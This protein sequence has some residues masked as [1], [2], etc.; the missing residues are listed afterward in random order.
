MR[1]IRPKQLNGAN[2]RRPVIP[3]RTVDAA[4]GGIPA[5]RDEATARLGQLRPSSSR[6]SRFVADIPFAA[7]FADQGQTKVLTGM[8]P[9][10]LRSEW[11]T[12]VPRRR[13]DVGRITK[14]HERTKLFTRS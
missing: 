12:S 2:R 4:V 10:A 14:L 5:A 13:F 9:A 7:G 3:D 11:L 8:T 1:N 6:L